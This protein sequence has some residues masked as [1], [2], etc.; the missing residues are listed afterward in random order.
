MPDAHPKTGTGLWPVP[1]SDNFGWV[2]D[3][4]SRVRP[5]TS[6]QPSPHRTRTRTG[7][8][9][10]GLHQPPPPQHTQAACTHTLNE[11]SN[12]SSRDRTMRTCELH[13]DRSAGSVVPSR[14]CVVITATTAASAESQRGPLAQPQPVPPSHPH[15]GPSRPSLQPLPQCPLGPQ[16]SARCTATEGRYSLLPPFPQH[17]C[18]LTFRHRLT[19]LLLGWTM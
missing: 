14:P 3:P 19:R 10:T 1:G 2:I 4:T 17:A 8:S 6:A 16:T 13:R 18:M 9:V 5:I 15:L 12:S 7:H 11:H